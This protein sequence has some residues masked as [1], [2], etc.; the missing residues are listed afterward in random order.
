M[1][2]KLQKKIN[3]FLKSKVKIMPGKERAIADSKEIEKLEQIVDMLCREKWKP[4][5]DGYIPMEVLV[6]NRTTHEPFHYS[7][8]PYGNENNFD[9]KMEAAVFNIKIASNDLDTIWRIEQDRRKRSG[10]EGGL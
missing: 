6:V 1:N 10:N 5:Y 8:Q 3:D 9:E 2:K 7:P 4:S